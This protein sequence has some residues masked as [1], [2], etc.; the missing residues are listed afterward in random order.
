MLILFMGID[1]QILTSIFLY[2]KVIYGTN[3][4]ESELNDYK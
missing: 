2:V 4:I 3:L 1:S